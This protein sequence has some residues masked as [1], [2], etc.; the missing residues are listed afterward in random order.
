MWDY[1][2]ACAL[3][4]RRPVLPIGELLPR[5]NIP[6]QLL[7]RV[8]RVAKGTVERMLF[9]ALRVR[10]KSLC[11]SIHKFQHLLV[12]PEIHERHGK[13]NFIIRVAGAAI[14]LDEKIIRPNNVVLL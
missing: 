6:A 9:M 12:H 5:Q 13:P 2:I 14:W 11:P 8:L 4:W 1:Q 3:A 7:S 10:S